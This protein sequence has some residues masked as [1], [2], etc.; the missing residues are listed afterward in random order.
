MSEALL[1]PRVR[2]NDNRVRFE[3]FLVRLRDAERATVQAYFDSE[4]QADKGSK[5]SAFGG[6]NMLRL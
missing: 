6:A 4:R 2:S 5:N 3:R 1:L